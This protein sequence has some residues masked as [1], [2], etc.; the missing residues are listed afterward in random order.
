MVRIAHFSDLHYG[1]KNLIEADRCFGAAIDMAMASGVNMG[2]VTLGINAAFLAVLYYGGTL[3]LAQQV[4]PPVLSLFTRFR[5]YLAHFCP[6]FSRFLRVFTASPRRFQRAPSRN[7]GPRNGGKGT[8]SGE[9]RPSFDTADANQ[10][11]NWQAS[12]RDMLDDEPWLQHFEATTRQAPRRFCRR[13]LCFF[14][15]PGANLFQ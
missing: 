14:W 12:V 6:V 5:P 8:K 7:P 2:S 9:L 4:I 15:L 10:R 13:L 11:I 3:V 1:P